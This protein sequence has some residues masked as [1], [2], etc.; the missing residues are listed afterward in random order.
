MVR[1]I[2]VENLTYGAY[3]LVLQCVAHRLQHSLRRRDVAGDAIG[4]KAEWPEKPSPNRP[5]V[6]TAVAFQNAAAI[7]RMISGLPGASER[8][9]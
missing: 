9:P 2:S 4:R 3:R 6:I 8:K 1:R 5:L 7:V